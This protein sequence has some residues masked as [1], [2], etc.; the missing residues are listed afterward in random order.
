MPAEI[1]L[2]QRP[3]IHT[4]HD[5]GVQHTGGILPN[6]ALPCEN[7]A[8][9][10]HVQ[11]PPSCQLT[12]YPSQFSPPCPCQG[13]WAC[14][15]GVWVLAACCCCL[16]VAGQWPTT[17]V[18]CCAVPHTLAVRTP[19]PPWDPRNCS[20]AANN[21][22]GWPRRDWWHFNLNTFTFKFLRLECLLLIL[23]RPPCQSGCLA[24]R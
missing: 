14:S 8:L 15:P 24:K 23:I 22:N 18:W 1:E 7:L 2:R 20:N 9:L 17:R 12:P 5:G 13:G 6:S 4:G 21:L 11:C 19:P 10:L 3:P 16:H